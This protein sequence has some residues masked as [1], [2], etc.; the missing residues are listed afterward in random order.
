[1]PL[2]RPPKRGMLGRQYFIDRAGYPVLTTDG[3]PV[4]IVVDEDTVPVLD[5]H[6]HTCR[7]ERPQRRAGGAHCMMRPQHGRKRKSQ[8]SQEGSQRPS[9]SALDLPQ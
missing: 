4:H 1:V 2:D 6:P 8:S 9:D 3:R 7:S 5:E